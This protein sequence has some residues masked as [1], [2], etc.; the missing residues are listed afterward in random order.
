MAAERVLRLG[1]YARAM[2]ASGAVRACASAV[3]AL[4]A[5]LAFAPA[6]TVAERSKGLRTKLPIVVIHSKSEIPDPNKVTARMRVI[7]GP[8]TNRVRH[9]ARDY[10]GLIGIELRGS[11]SLTFPKK[12][13]SVETRE[14]NGD[15][16]EVRLLGLPKEEDWVL[17]APYLDRS[18]LRNV[19]AYAFSRMLGRYASRTRFVELVL[20]RRYQGVYVLM[21]KLELGPTRINVEDGEGEKAFLVER[22]S[23]EKLKPEDDIFRLPVTGRPVI[24]DDPGLD[25]LTAAEAAAIEGYVGDFERALYSRDFTDPVHGYRQFLDVPT[26]VDYVL[27]TELFKNLDAFV[28]SFFMHRGAGTGLRL[29]PVWDFDWS[30]G[31]PMA[32]PESGRSPEG[33]IG[34]Q[35]VWAR[36]L[37]ADPAFMGALADRWWQVRASGLLEHL[38]QRISNHA[39]KLRRPGARDF[40]RWDSAFTFESEVNRLR[41]WLAQRVAWIDANINAA[42][43]PAN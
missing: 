16:R 1:G 40:R 9:E 21:E 27:V 22:T 7:D 15:N 29:G 37:F 18:L 41:S 38:D 28:N 43:P 2:N 13:Y 24:W 4:L 17:H 5:G 10:E 19:S 26:A 12:Q 36:R 30:S 32:A 20:N 39:R 42:A 34:Q 33:W 35:R 6:P 8:G 25:D 31:D 11:S 23:D 14:R 3:F